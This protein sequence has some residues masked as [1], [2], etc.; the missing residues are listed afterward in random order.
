MLGRSHALSGLAAGSAYAE[1]VQHARWPG[2]IALGGLTAGMALIPDLDSCGSTGARSLGFLSGAVSH[3]VRAVSG[4]HRH[5][6][7]SLTGI[8][9]F[10]GLAWLAAHY[11]HDYAGMAG[12]ALLLTLAVSSAL[13]A[14]HVTGSHLSDLTA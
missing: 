2:V 14:L 5:A 13:E 1:F 6:T 10:T 8:A 9:V 12:L 4:G 7:H 11:R 3:V